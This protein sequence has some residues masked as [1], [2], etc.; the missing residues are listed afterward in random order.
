MRMTTFFKRILHLMCT[1]VESAV[2]GDLPEDENDA[3]KKGLVIRVRPR[4]QRLRCGECGGRAKG[5]HGKKGKIR[6]W[7]HLS[8]LGIPVWLKCRI[9]RVVCSKCGIR[10]MAVPWAR[11]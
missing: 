8:I 5:R 4:W 1:I 7:R 10:T 6:H 3:K 9:Y 2:L 11:V